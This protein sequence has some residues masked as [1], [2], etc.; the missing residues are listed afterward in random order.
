M[1]LHVCLKIWVFHI[2]WSSKYERL[3]IDQG[4]CKDLQLEQ[5]SSGLSSTVRKIIK[6]E[7]NICCV[8]LYKVG[9]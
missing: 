8:V 2:T 3:K 6:K 9:E 5:I 4:D 7:S 1:P